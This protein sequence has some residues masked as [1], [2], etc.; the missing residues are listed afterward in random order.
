MGRNGEFDVDHAADRAMGA[1]D[2]AKVRGELPPGRDPVELAR[3]LTTFVQGLRVV[4]GARL[5]RS[6]VED[7]LA[8]A[9][10]A[11]D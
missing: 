1:L 11:L 2:R 10:R 3:F 7:A 5:G 6:F 8:V 9:M 4:G